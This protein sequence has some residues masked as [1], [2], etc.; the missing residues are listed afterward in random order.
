MALK[1]LISNTELDFRGRVLIS[2]AKN[3]ALVISRTNTISGRQGR[4]AIQT[5]ELPWWRYFQWGTGIKA[6]HFKNA[7]AKKQIQDNHV[8]SQASDSAVRPHQNCKEQKVFAPHRVLRCT[9]RTCMER[10]CLEKKPGI[11]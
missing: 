5:R 9:N 1:K 11:L 2:V 3:T 6:A 4:R 7:V 10:E 8:P